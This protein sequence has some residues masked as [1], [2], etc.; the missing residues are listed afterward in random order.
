MFLLGV[1]VLAGCQQ[2]NSTNFVSNVVT[3]PTKIQKIAFYYALSADCNSLGKTEV[4]IITPP[5]NG[6]LKI[7]FTDD[8][9]SYRS[10]DQRFHCN[11]RRVP[12]TKV[13]FIPNPNFA[14]QETIVTEGFYPNGRAAK[15]TSNIT[16]R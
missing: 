4:R 15:L 3:T 11:S 16:V 8:F 14:G 5:S 7:E 1:L 13:I 2:G 10:G 9:P 12:G 6:Q